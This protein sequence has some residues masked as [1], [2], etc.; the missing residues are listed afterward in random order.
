MS[1]FF[2]ATWNTP[3]LIS[4]NERELLLSVLNILSEHRSWTYLSQSGFLLIFGFI[5]SA[6]LVHTPKGEF[7][8]FFYIFYDAETCNFFFF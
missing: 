6:H 5:S 3:P 7:L 4:S 2:L 8:L 1:F